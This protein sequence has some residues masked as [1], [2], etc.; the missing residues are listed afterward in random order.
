MSLITIS[1][2]GDI[3]CGN[4]NVMIKAVDKLKTLEDVILFSLKRRNVSFELNGS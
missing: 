3:F 1:R 2:E 4:S